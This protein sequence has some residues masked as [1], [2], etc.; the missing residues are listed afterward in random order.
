MNKGKPNYIS[1]LKVPQNR[2]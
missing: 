2:L 1:Q